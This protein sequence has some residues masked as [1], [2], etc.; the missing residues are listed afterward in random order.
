MDKE[1]FMEGDSITFHK[2]FTNFIKSMKE[3]WGDNHM[4]HYM[5]CIFFFVSGVIDN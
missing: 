1:K 4:T 5:V 2:A 3:A